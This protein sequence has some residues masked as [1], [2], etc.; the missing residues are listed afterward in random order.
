MFVHVLSWAVGEAKLH[1][2]L[3]LDNPAEKRLL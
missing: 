3:Q 2:D 1:I